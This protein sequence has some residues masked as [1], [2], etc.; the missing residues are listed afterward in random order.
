MGF[1]F[2][3]GVLFK[4]MDFLSVGVSFKT[5]VTVAMEGDA[6]NEAMPVISQLMKI[7]NPNAPDIPAKSKFE[8]DLGW[9]MWIGGGIAL[10][11]IDKL[12]ICFDVQY[13][14]WSESEEKITTE[15]MDWP[16]VLG[17][18]P[19]TTED[20]DLTWEDAVQIRFGAQY[21]LM[22][23]FA[24]RVGAYSD[25]APSP[26]ETLTIIFPSITYT[27]LTFG[28]S[29]YLGS[30]GIDFGIEYLMGTERDISWELYG[31]RKA[32]GFDPPMPGL[33]NMNI[34]AASI[35]LS[36]RFGACEKAEE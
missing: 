12:T 25:P 29:Y 5:A 26:D 36:Y 10:T 34:V 3:A 20:M 33:H 21:W 19:T 30:L 1:G 22:D 23:N 16:D 15:Y 35:G 9:P 17:G 11:P 32:A 2:S 18:K 24:L 8:R 27:G 6:N 13:S 4:P 31:A 7:V 28:A 14:Q